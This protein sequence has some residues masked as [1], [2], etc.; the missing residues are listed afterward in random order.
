MVIESFGYW[1]RLNTKNI[2]KKRSVILLG[3]FLPAIVV[4]QQSSKLNEVYESHELEQ[5]EA[6]NPEAIKYLEFKANHCFAVQDLSGKKD[7]AELPDIS[8]L[9]KN[10]EH[11]KAPEL[12][13]ENF[14]ADS[15]NPLFYDVEGKERTGYYRIGE[16]GVL[17]KV[18]TEESCK[19]Y[20]K[21]S[22]GVK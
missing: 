5:L 1:N 9:N 18:F 22:S 3:V 11:S 4:A 12:N 10:T 14:D 15:F 2:M 20:Y 16:T 6:T 21:R 19:S 17:L 8:E 7:I 13:Q